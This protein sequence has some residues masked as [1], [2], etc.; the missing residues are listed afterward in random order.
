MILATHNSLTY[1][2]PQWWLRP[3]AWIGRC[4]SFTIEQQVAYGVQYFDIRVR[5]RGQ[6]L[7]SAHGLLTYNVNL[8]K[9]LETIQKTVGGVVRLTLEDKKA[10]QKDIDTFINFCIMAELRFEKIFF[11]GGYQKGTWKYLYDFDNEYT[12]KEKYWTFSKK[13]WFPFPKLY[14][15]LNNKGFKKVGCDGY[16]MLDFIQK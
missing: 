8:L 2:K 12:V 16:L 13:R 5:V 1:L 6:N 7:M 14:A 15:C 11:V 9:I 10:S 3:F 4:Q